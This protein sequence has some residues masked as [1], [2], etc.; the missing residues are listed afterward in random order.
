MSSEPDNIITG[1]AS[2]DYVATVTNAE[3]CSVTATVVADNTACFI[4]RG[5]SPNNDGDNDSFDISNLEARNIKIF[6]RYGM[7]V[8]EKENY[9][10]EWHGQS[11]QGTLPTGTY[12][13]MITLSAG[14]QI[15]GWVYLQREL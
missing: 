5:I 12:F 14:E 9:R 7:M 1:F 8:Y 11:E 10:D 3:G 15:T 13:Y 6:N 2:G 4:P